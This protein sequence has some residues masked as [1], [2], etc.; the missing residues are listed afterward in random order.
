MIYCIWYPCGG[1][2]HFLNGII[3]LRGENF[4]RP[5]N[6]EIE[7]GSNGH[8][9]NLDTPVPTYYHD[10]K[11]WN[12]NFS[13]NKN[14][15][16][17]IDNGVNNESKRFLN[18]FHDTPTVIKLCYD[19]YSWPV[20]A[21]TMICKAMLSNLEQT[22]STDEWNTDA[23]WAQREKYF[24]FLRDHPLRHAW[25]S[26]SNFHCINIGDLTDYHGLESTL[27]S[28]NIKI[29][30]FDDIWTEWWNCNSVYFRPILEAENIVRNFDQIP[31]QDLTHIKDLWTQA[32]VYYYIWLKFGIEVPHN[33]YADW[34]SNTGDLY[35]IVRDKI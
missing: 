18:F 10:P 29:S 22:L 28:C 19:D 5:N 27:K 34:F 3:S 30:K 9:H 21:S 31:C 25:R 17:L 32:V 14:Y 26:E 4:L 6:R 35:D 16:V 7:F 20:L 24:L 15:S 33:T 1:F 12:Y 8:S 13:E 23:D 11:T 2:G